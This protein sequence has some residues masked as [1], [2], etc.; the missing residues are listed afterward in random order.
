MIAGWDLRH[1]NRA[2]VD[3]QGL[4]N[5]RRL[6]RQRTR[7]SQGNLQAMGLIQPIA[8]SRIPALPRIELILY[9]L[10]P[11]FQGI[12][13]VSLV[14]AVVLAIDRD[15]GLRGQPVVAR[16]HLHARIRRHD[17]R[18][19]RR[20]AGGPHDRRPGWSRGC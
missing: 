14:V 12:V 1:D 4:S 9:L 7:W 16:L 10:M 11:F 17:A 18:L 15:R 2:S 20:Q 13:G 19:R 3:Q 8:R 5:L 6:L